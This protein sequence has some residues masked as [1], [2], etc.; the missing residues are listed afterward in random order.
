[1]IPVK[2][3]QQSA[4]SQQV[5]A[6]PKVLAVASRGGH[7]IELLRLRDACKGADV[8]YVT[9]VLEYR[10]TVK[11]GRFRLVIEAT[12]DHKLRL[13]LL[14][15]QMLWI[16]VV[17]RPGVIMTTGAAPGF[18]A[19]RLGKWLG[20]RTLWID[21]IA[22]AEELSMSGQLAATH[23]DVVLTQWS[24]LASPGG[25]EFKGAVV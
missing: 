12:R 23:A 7:W 2:R 13:M 17:E 1:M 25:A 6:R 9:T 4:D 10:E 18:I 8:V 20:I 24:H 5:A 21:S 19:V 3:Q 14:A 22:N 16:L 11:D 15:L